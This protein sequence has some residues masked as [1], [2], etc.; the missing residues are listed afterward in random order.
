[1]VQFNRSSDIV[2][3]RP[4]DFDGANIVIAICLAAHSPSIEIKMNLF[5]NVYGWSG[6]ENEWN[7]KEPSERM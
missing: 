6:L 3:L 7:K 1:M 4:F 2:G 5:D